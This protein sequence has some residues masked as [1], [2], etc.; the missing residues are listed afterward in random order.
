[1]RR[2]YILDALRA[3]FALCV[4]IGHLG[5]FPLFGPV[6]QADA[7]ADTLAR[8]LRTLVFGPPAVVA[9]FVISGFCIHY[10][11]RREANQNVPIARFYARRYLRI[12][13]PVAV[14]L[15]AFKVFLPEVVIIGSKTILWHSTLWSIVVEEI[16]YAAYP[17]LNWL[18]RIY[19]WKTLISTSFCVS[20][21]IAFYCFPA[22]EWADI[23][24][25]ATALT[26]LPVWLMGSQLAEIAPAAVRE[27][28]VPQIWLR[29]LVSWTIMWLAVILHFH[30]GIYQTVTGL[31]IGIWCYFW[32]RDEICYYRNRKPWQAL[33]RA[34]QWSYSLYLVHPL[35]IAIIYKYDL[36]VPETRLG[37]VMSLLLVFG[38]SY[39][40]YLFA[41]RP[42]HNL[43]RKIGAYQ[44]SVSPTALPQPARAG[45]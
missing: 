35:V 18:G 3:V 25:T 31:W 14:I 32:L 37:W 11:Y 39:S 9:F 13:V 44:R 40:F 10:P 15:A 28:S 24:I 30:A 33:Q 8:G 38:G 26:L 22:R 21:L 16:Y 7:F 4:V 43:A 41:E 36:A 29:R 34:G 1:L 27:F 6:G 45:S 19:G 23:G 2:F 12:L 5:V 20:L 17:L 42:A